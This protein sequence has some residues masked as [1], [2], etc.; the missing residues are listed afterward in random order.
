MP[1]ERSVDIDNLNDFRY[2][3]FLIEE[4]SQFEAASAPQ[5]ITLDE[6]P[7]SCDPIAGLMGQKPIEPRQKT[8]AEVIREFQTEKWSDVLQQIK[9]RPGIKV[10][11]IDQWRLGDR[12]VSVMEKGRYYHMNA[13]DGIHRDFVR[14]SEALERHLAGARALVELGAGY[15][16]TLLN[17]ATRHGWAKHPMH[18]AEYTEAGMECIRLLAE[19]HG[20]KIPVGYCDF[21]AG[22][23]KGIDIPPSSLI[24]THY[25]AHYCPQLGDRFVPFFRRLNP[26]MVIHFEPCYEHCN[27][28]AISGLLAK[29]YIEVNDYNRDLVTVLHRHRENG[30]IEIVQEEKAVMGVNALLPMSIIA[31]RPV[32]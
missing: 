21:R 32:R 27:D 28:N 16:S 23:L 13:L 30:E 18:A 4:A 1:A 10:E 22:V 24:Y 7:S 2:A 12:A 29:R 25:A 26:H 17:L 8:E 19:N 14:T 3:E 6:L 20:L 11:E 5:E 9:S 15:G 31:W